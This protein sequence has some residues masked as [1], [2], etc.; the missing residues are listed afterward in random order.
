[1][2]GIQ[3][4]G[5]RPLF[6][7]PPAPDDNQRNGGGE[8]SGRS[9]AW[10]TWFRRQP[11]RTAFFVKGLLKSLSAEETYWKSEDRVKWLEAAAK[12]FDLMY[13]GGEGNLD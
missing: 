10:Q 2:P 1:M 12:C 4:P 8:G 6:D 9:R 5:A 11:E 3:G 13:G 7:D